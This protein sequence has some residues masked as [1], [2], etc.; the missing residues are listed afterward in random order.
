MPAAVVYDLNDGFYDHSAQHVPFGIAEVTGMLRLAW[1]DHPFSGFSQQGERPTI[2]QEMEDAR[3]AEGSAYHFVDPSG[4][5]AT[6]FL[7][8][9][10]AAAPNGNL[11][12]HYFACRLLLRCDVATFLSQLANVRIDVGRIAFVTVAPPK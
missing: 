8:P 11:L 6:I 1:G 4:R 10:P 12:V 3:N 2:L 5:Q 9:G 7:E